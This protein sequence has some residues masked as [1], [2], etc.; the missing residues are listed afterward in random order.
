MMSFQSTMPRKRIS[1]SVDVEAI[2]AMKKAAKAANASV[3]RYVET[4]I[5]EDSKDQGFLSESYE[6]LGETR[7]GGQYGRT[8]TQAKDRDD[9]Q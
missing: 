3:S 6:P 1:I 9:K 7:G 5:I 4:L 2:D 8:D